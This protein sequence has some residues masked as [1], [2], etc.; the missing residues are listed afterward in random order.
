MMPLRRGPRAIPTAAARDLGSV[1]A[2]TAAVR[3]LS[4][5]V[6][7]AALAAAFLLARDLDTERSEV[8]PTGSSGVVVLD[9][10]FSIGDADY[11][12]TRGMLEQVIE[13]GRPAGLVVFS[14]VPYEL[15][16]PGSPAS[17]LRPLLRLFPRRS[18]LVRANPWK[19]GFQ[20]G[21]RISAGLE[22]ARR[23]LRRDGVEEGAILLASDLQT[24][25]DDL[26][27]LS[28]TLAR[29]DR[30][31]IALRLVPLSPTGESRAFF[32]S[33]VGSDAFVE[34]VAPAAP[35]RPL[36]ARPEGESPLAL[37]VLGSLVL[38]A[39]AAHERGAGRLALPAAA[40]GRPS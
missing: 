17:A 12:R 29:I 18:G 39:L 5:A 1:A 4:V 8:L 14:D 31:G 21:T 10:S 7:C 23:I 27:Q 19:E 20:S 2:R 37:L 15:L 32:E 40:R 28:R 35:G 3:W 30:D 22:L 34:N 13:A 36:E 25:P 6:A 9:L 38:L 16:P 26:S 11:R 24:S 33:A